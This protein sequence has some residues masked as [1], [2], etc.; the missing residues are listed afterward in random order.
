[1]F[2]WYF[3]RLSSN[4]YYCMKLSLRLT[5]Q[6]WLP[7]GILQRPQKF[8]RSHRTVW[9]DDY[10][11]VIKYDTM[12]HLHT[13]NWLPYSCASSTDPQ[14]ENQCILD[15]IAIYRC[16]TDLCVS[17]TFLWTIQLMTSAARPHLLVEFYSI[18]I[19]MI[20]WD[21]NGENGEIRTIQWWS[22]TTPERCSLTTWTRNHP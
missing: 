9:K 13:D 2:Q 5:R 20:K 7:L 4:S 16:S 8:P 18:I 15:S 21:W 14:S 17:I 1:M 3:G 12:F 11:R 10:E 6:I 19:Q 22:Q